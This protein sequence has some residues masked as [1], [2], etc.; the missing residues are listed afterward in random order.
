MRMV[1]PR[2]RDAWGGVPERSATALLA[3]W[4]DVDPA[5]EAAYEAWHAGEHVPERLT[6]PGLQWACRYGRVAAGAMP[7]YLT[8]YGLRDA[9]VLEEEPYQ[10]LLRQPTP[11][12]RRMRPALRNVSRWVCALVEAHG[13]DQGSHLAVWTAGWTDDAADASP[14]PWAHVSGARGRLVAQRLPHASP[15]PWLQPG[16][17]P[18]LAGERLLA[19]CLDGP[20]PV[21]AAGVYARLPVGL[22][23]SDSAG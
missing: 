22:Q 4:N 15:L 18:G 5:Q 10:R 7:R 6:V 3:L 13:L 21:Q 8:L 9:E 16:Q 19:V 17:G 23:V 12:S 11:M 2:P 20:G 14:G 1:E